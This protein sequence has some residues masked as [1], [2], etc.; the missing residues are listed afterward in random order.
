M[1]WYY[2]TF[3]CGHEGRV[4][5]TGPSKDRQRKADW[6]FN[7]SC[8]E[9]KTERRLEERKKR[10]QEAVG[11][12]M[13]MQLPPLQGS[14]KQI[15][16]ATTLRDQLIKKFEGIDTTDFD[17]RD[18]DMYTED[19]LKKILEYILENK[20]SASYYIDIRFE[21][22]IITIKREAEYAL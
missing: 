1:A 5:I 11:R 18:L 6:R 17:Y 3:N 19:D 2:G 10:Q 14:E 15:A 7:D 13:S 20:T 8:Y 22:S 9:C 4:D 12:A 16:W 21:P